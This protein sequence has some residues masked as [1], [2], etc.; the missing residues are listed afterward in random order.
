M[1][2]SFEEILNLMRQLQEMRSTVS[3]QCGEIGNLHS[4]LEDA[5]IPHLY[6]RRNGGYALRYFGDNDL[7]TCSMDFYDP[8]LVC[9]VIEFPGSYGFEDDLLEVSGLIYDNEDDSVTGGLTAERVFQAIKEHYEGTAG[10]A[11]LV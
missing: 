2:D 6:G 9:D 10:A 3:S 4:M 11:P 5:G 1:F 8:K 7:G